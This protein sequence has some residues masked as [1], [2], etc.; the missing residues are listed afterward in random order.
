ME[1]SVEHKDLIIENFIDSYH[2]LTI[3][4]IMMLK[5]IKNNCPKAQFIMKIDDD[6]YL[7]LPK[8]ISFVKSDRVKSNDFL[9][10][11]LYTSERPHR[12]KNSKWL[13]FKTIY[14]LKSEG[15][16]KHHGYCSGFKPI[17][18]SLALVHCYV[19]MNIPL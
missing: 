11:K 6:V 14:Q 16:K 17:A 19:F 8:L 13:V 10:G 7:N 5:W 9:I 18:L 1:E 12:D 15:C 3:K 2:N 4:S